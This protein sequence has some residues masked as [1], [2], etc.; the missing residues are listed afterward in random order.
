MAAAET[1][2]TGLADGA[3]PAGAASSQSQQQLGKPSLADVIAKHEAGHPLT[4]QER[5]IL[6]AARRKAKPRVTSPAA[7]QNLFMEPP[8]APAP[9]PGTSQ[10][11]P[12]APSDNPFLE[13]ETVG[14]VPAPADVNSVVTAEACRMA[15]DAICDAVDQGTQLWVSYEATKAGADK[16]TVKQYE[17]AVALQPR[18]RK[19]MVENSAPV[20]L[21]AC[22]LLKCEPQ[23]LPDILKKGGFAAGI[24]A[25]AIAVTAAI[26]SIRESKKENQP[27]Q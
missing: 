1:T 3:T 26:K 15:A 12:V 14:T 23:Q 21:A 22:K 6:G 5:G 8:A 20:I 13:T 11:K 25:H 19:L 10:P 18:N 7:D 24:F 16:Q 17:S 27:E 4:H 9:A 2:A